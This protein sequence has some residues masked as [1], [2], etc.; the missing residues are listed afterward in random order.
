MMENVKRVGIIGTGVAGLATA[1]TLIAAG[2]DCTLFERN[3]QLGGVWADGYS[4]F[5]VQAPKELYEFP[6]WPLPDDAPNFTPGPYFQKYMEGYVDHFGFRDCIQFNTHVT[7]LEQCEDGWTV[8]TNGGDGSQRI[9]FD[10]VVIATGMF[11]N[12][13]NMPTFPGADEFEG[14]ILHNSELKARNQLSGR[15]VA[16][17][18]YG[19]SASDAA[20]EAA[21]VAKDVHIIFR[22]AHWPVPRKLAGILPIKWGALSRLAGAFLPP[23]QRP[24]PVQ[25]WLHGVGKPIVWVYWRLVE[26]IIRCQYRLGTKIANG[27]NLLPTAPFQFDA[28]GEATM[29][30]RPE[31]FPLVRKGRIQAHRT[32]IDHYTPTGVALNDGAELD[33]DC[34]VLATGWKSDYSY[35]PDDA[36]AALGDDDDGIYLYRHI[37]QPKLPNLAFVGRATSFLSVLTFCLQARWLA[38]LITG[39]V[40]LPSQADMLKEIN[41]IKAWKRSTMP[42]SPAR[43]ARILLY[44]QNYHDELLGDFGADP[45]RKRGIFA[46]LKELFAPYESRDYQ[47]IAADSVEMQR[48]C[49]FEQ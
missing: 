17:V 40:K 35:L 27:K 2:L 22:A 43:G 8:E 32:V 6:D 46:P 38:E 20:L 48:D 18:G 3:E 19:K 23:Y 21:A 11:S 26:L 45:L 13:A 36:L 10:L 24:T 39:R 49:D 14:T 41:G 47:S 7:K 12:V 4:N 29:L 15:R 33:V 1:K 28:F 37:L 42:F 5:G 16:V 44:G 30:P 25:R 34:V 9:D 31:F